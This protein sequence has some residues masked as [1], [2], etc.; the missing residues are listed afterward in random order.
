MCN[1]NWPGAFIIFVV[2]VVVKDGEDCQIL[3]ICGS[4]KECGFM[5]VNLPLLKL[6]MKDIIE[7]NE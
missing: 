1:V 6:A 7:G 5:T 3:E 2:F 4:L